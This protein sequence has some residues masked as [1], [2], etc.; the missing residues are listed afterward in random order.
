M[1]QNIE[2]TLTFIRQ[3]RKMEEGDDTI[4]RKIIISNVPDHVADHLWSSWKGRGNDFGDFF[5]NLGHATQGNFI[6]S[7]GISIPGLEQYK[8]DLD[9]TPVSAL[10]RDPPPMINWLHELLKFFYNHGI[11]HQC[12]PGVYLKTIPADKEKQYGNSRNW[13]DY[14]LGLDEVECA[15]VLSAIEDYTSVHYK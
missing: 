2:Q 7:W 12:A 3:Y 13:A 8:A 1:N 10:F 11:M 14:I 5:L 15:S 4:N 6:E 9:R